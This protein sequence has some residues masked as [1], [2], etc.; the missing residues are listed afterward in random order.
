VDWYYKAAIVVALIWGVARALGV[1]GEA[2]RDLDLGFI[3]SFML[4]LGG[5]AAVFLIIDRVAKFLG[6]RRE[7]AASVPGAGA[8]N[9]ASAGVDAGTASSLRD[10]S[11]TVRPALESASVS[12]PGSPGA[13]TTSRRTARRKRR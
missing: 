7:P 10:P 4:T 8:P 5:W 1:Y 12:P 3:T 11:A 13:S 2:A 6:W 9:V